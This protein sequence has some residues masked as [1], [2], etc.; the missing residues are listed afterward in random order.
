MLPPRKSF[1]I[2]RPCITPAQRA[3]V[4]ATYSSLATIFAARLTCSSSLSRVSSTGLLGARVNKGLSPPSVGYMEP[5][6]GRKTLSREGASAYER[7]STQG[8]EQGHP[9]VG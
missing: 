9:R 8:G 7:A 1:C 5:L 4:L 2:T 3:Q 6:W